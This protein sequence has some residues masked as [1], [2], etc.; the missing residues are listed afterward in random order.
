MGLTRG[1]LT[2]PRMNAHRLVIIA[3]ALT[4]IVAAA[5]ATA[6]ATFSGQAL[7]RA[8]RHD[9][10]HATGTSLFIS[11]SVNA[12]QAAQYSAVLPGQI[13]S[14]LGGTAFR[15]YQADW[16]DP[17]GFVP[18]SLPA[19]PATPSAAAGSGLTG[20]TPIAEAA[21]LGDITGQAELVS[22][23]WPGAPVHG[24]P[25]PA[26][27]PA[28]AAALLH[29]TVGD[30]L[31]MRDRITQG[32]VRFVVTGLYRPRQ[33]SSPYWNL[34]S[35]APSGSS[36][37]G[38]FTTFG[39]FTVRP[40][41]FAAGL[42]VNQGTWLA[43]PQTA[44]IPADQLT[45][46]AANVNGL[47]SALANA[48]QLPSLTLTT[49]LPAVLDGIAS[50]LD[51]AR[52]LLA[53]CAVLLFLLAAAAL[54]AAARLLAGQREGESAMLTAR[55]ANRWQLVRLTAAE[56]IPLCV[57]AAAAGGVFG[58]LL[59]R[60]LVSGGG[61]GP[62]GSAWLAAVVVA[63]G[64]AVIML[65]P[66]LSTVA[67]G[68][69]RARRGRQAAISGVSRAGADLALVL[70]A[71][72]AG[73][74][75]RHYSAVSAGANGNF[76]ID[77][78]VVIAPAL[79]LAGGTVLALRLLP[80]GGKAGD[81]LAARGRGL[82][83]A[84]ASWQISRQPIRQG[85]AALLIV[86]AVA[87]GTLA[88]SQRQS[89]T[90]SDHDQAA[91][92]TGADVRVDTSQPLTAAQ[93]AGVVS[94]PGVQ[95]AMPVAAFPQTATNGV[96]L[97]P[98]SDQAA[99]VT[100]L[101]ADQSPVNAAALFGRI[102]PTGP[103]SGVPLPGHAAQVSL[104]ARV[105]P[106][107]L[108]LAP[109]TV[110][111]SVEDA[112]HE[113]FQLDAGTLPADGRDHTLTV[114]LNDQ[115][116]G[117]GAAGAAIYPLRLISVGLDYTLPAKRTHE[118]ATFTVDGFSAGPG[119]TQ[120]PGTALGAWPAAGSSVELAG[121][122]QTT[123]TVGP[124]GM[125]AVT[126]KGASGTAFSVTFEPGY[127]LASS[128][129]PGGPSSPVSGQLT[130]TGT[131]PI[132]VIPGVA[133][134]SFLAATNASVGSVVQADVNGAVL[135]VK[136]VGKVRT[137][138]TVSLSGGAL[139]VDLGRLQDVLTSSSL[140]P[141][142]P[143][144][145]WLA[146][147]G[148]TSAVPP[149]LTAGLTGVLPPGSDIT[150]TA[151]VAAGLLSD[152]L[153]TVPQ[154]ALLVVAIAAAVLAIT[155]FCVSIAAGVRQR[156]AENALLAALGVPP[157]SAAGQLCLE[158][159]MLSLPAALAGLILGVVLAELLIPAITLTSSAT[160][161]VPP[162]LIQFG[163]AQVLPLA[164]AVAVLPVLAAALTV[165]RRPDAAAALRAAEAA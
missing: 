47:R 112:V 81:R 13:R 100:L 21:A 120:V 65:I 158:K 138:P 163:W 121:V 51:V 115:T 136:I 61:A 6:L 35:V 18:G 87:T 50:D 37:A 16:S 57:L 32:Y 53:I 40:A 134:Q 148:G 154:Q 22:G 125:P 161:P 94:L 76:G 64:A 85:G 124:S 46:V 157:G 48:Q 31:R 147:S 99:N 55:G 162:V 131:P 36:T 101:R 110:S 156:R 67:P 146:T 102:A 144:Q 97:A 24:Q 111:V 122:R 34:S 30:V 23:N 72:L 107:S 75:L 5:L 39:P 150:S 20:N 38:G 77:P 56:A 143:D 88:L 69:A 155:G 73:W 49:S 83:A 93:A 41:A 42:P 116:G 9:L 44:S 1:S 3:A 80:A 129:V 141:A 135:S 137:F 89:W 98:N 12:S 26:A 113:V 66:A 149:G 71:V 119:T 142:Q 60:L 25:V 54:L 15:L 109:V 78:V 96:V 43:E 59:A 17:L 33:L 108:G 45:A 117:A 127:G 92:S 133:T 82:T 86:L 68:A 153:S 165:A 140:A 114:T 70:L 91:F 151:G 128:G 4:T 62:T 27:L 10:G 19:T 159:L 104:V 63:A 2:L 130:L 79:A 152:P 8:V 145:W 126:A 118:P 105:G 95:H 74:Q 164:L 29:V 11:G 7:P 106:A 28:T 160:T 52:S 139:I 90:R 14:A 123:G 58:V 103:P 84:L 132:A